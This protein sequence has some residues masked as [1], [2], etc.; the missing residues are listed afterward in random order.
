MTEI[1]TAKP[2]LNWDVLTI[3]RPGLGRDVPAGKEELM[4]V[5]NSS[6]L[7]YGE[8]DAV[9]VDTFLTAEQAQV[10]VEWVAASGKNLT[11]IY[12][13][14]GH[15]D[16]FF[17]LAPLL[18]RFPNA[19]AFATPAVV[20]AMHAQLSPESIG[21]FWRRLFPGQIPDRLLIAEPL[22]GDSLELEGHKLVVV[23]TGHTDTSHSTCL[24]VPSTGLIVGGDVVYNGIHPYLG[25]TDTQS[26]LE[27][28]AALDKLEALQPQTVIAGHKL[29]ENADDP[30]II[31]ETRQYLLDFNRLNEATTTARELYDAMLELYPNR[32][33]PGSLWGASNAAKK[34]G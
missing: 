30:R 4:W 29:P 7:I 1:E 32:A 2:G 10:L 9:L 26:R 17:G 18:E 27:W 21:N 11:T 15:G 8:R 16:H 12:V 5:V 25:E 14:H 23:N 20:E 22:D 24:Y 19:K 34:Q 3:K 6:T 13:T 28:I 33:N 31:S